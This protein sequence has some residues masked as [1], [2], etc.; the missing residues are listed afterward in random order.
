M[1]VHDEAAFQEFKCKTIMKK[2]ENMI[3]EVADFLVFNP[4]QKKEGEWSSFDE[5]ETMIMVHTPAEIK[6]RTK[7]ILPPVLPIKPLTLK[8]VIDIARVECPNYNMKKIYDGYD[9][10]MDLGYHDE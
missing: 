9:D 7:G 1:D 3:D 10:L 6:R 2:V 4:I 8:K 5:G